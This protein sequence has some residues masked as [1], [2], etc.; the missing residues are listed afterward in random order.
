MTG[1]IVQVSVSAGGV[2]K[3]AVDSA[4]ITTLGL[5]GD[6][7]RDQEH[8]GG[9]ERAVCIFA[10]EAIEALRAEGHPIVPGG[11]GENLT[12]AGL[13]WSAV[14]PD[15]ILQ[16]GDDV[17]VEITRYK[18]HPGWSR[19]YARVLVPGSVRTGDLV[20]LLAGTQ[21]RQ[22]VGSLQL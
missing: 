12:I 4:K 20:R 22:I 10:A 1:R 21:A 5:E 17:I 8:H 16:I 9:P 7:H 11:L 18:R 6:G 14:V 19:V 13:D 15:A 3:T 2:P